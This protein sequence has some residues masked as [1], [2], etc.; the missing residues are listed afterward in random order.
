MEMRMDEDGVVCVD[1]IFFVL[2]C[3]VLF[4]F[5]TCSSCGRGQGHVHAHETG[6]EGERG[7]EG[8]RLKFYY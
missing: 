1:M 6:K 2:F 4:F 5:C 8:G 3:I 7:G